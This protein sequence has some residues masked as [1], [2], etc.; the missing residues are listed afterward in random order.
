MEDRP[1]EKI[2]FGRSDLYVSRVAL[3][4]WQAGKVG[5]GDVQDKDIIDGIRKGAD[6]GINFI[7]TADIYGFGY[8]EELVGKALKGK[9]GIFVIATKVG[10][11]WDRAK[12][13]HKLSVSDISRDLSPKYIMSAVEESLRRLQTDYIDLYQCHWPDPKT[14]LEDIAET[15]ERL[16]EQGKTRWWGVSN[17]SVED[18]KKILDMECK[19]FVSDQPPF[20][21]V[22]RNIEK[23]L[24]PFAKKNGVALMVYSPLGMG[25][26]TGKY[27]ALPRFDSFD[28]RIYNE[29]FTDEEKFR[30]V[31][32]AIE[33][34][35]HIAKNHG[36]IFGQVA[37]AWVLHKGADVAIC[38][39]KNPKQV[40]ENAKSLEVK[41]SPDEIKE[42]DENFS[43]ALDG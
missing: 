35:E 28:W 17:F 22:Q 33:K 8:S 23:E 10:L 43:F 1:S 6:L 39:F 13:R 36:V 41:L 3:G 7:D 30:K 4:L 21:L 15:M 32:E 2:K 40:E 37:I 25:L 5:W 18:I 9:R 38:G 12:P 31:V 11:R 19:R 24:I 42:L 27:K 14:P 16:C 29:Y 34:S 20:S 26:L